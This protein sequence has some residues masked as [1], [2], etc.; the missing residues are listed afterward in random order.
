MTT[1]R[2][3]APIAGAEKI[4]RN[5]VPPPPKL[6]WLQLDLL[7]IDESYQR[8]LSG[9]SMALI[10]KLVAHWD[11]NC[12]KPLSVAPI[13]DGRYEIVD[14]QHTA[15]AASSHGSIDTLPCLVLT[16]ET[17]EARA[18]AFVGINSDRVNLT[19]FAIYRAQVAAGDPEAVAVDAGVAAAGATLIDKLQPWQEY[20][21]GSCATV[22]TLLQLARSGGKNR[23]ARLLK[24]AKAG[25]VGPVPGALLKGLELITTTPEPP[26]DEALSKALIS[27]DNDE[28][29]RRVR[30]KRFQRPDLTPAAA[31][32]DVVRSLVA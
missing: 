6:A 2:K 31:W 9:R 12:F 25:G 10:R 23:V 3:L 7:V 18:Q 30:Q 1:L 15:M 27:I 14:G 26:S 28:L 19:R 4:I 22:A 17:R 21:P 20:E 32:A 5:P 13:G 11:W 16:A 24:I 8:S 29:G